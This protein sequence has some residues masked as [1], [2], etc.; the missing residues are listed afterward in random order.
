VPATVTVST[1]W[2]TAVEACLEAGGDVLLLADSWRSP[3]LCTLRPVL[4]TQL[5]A[6]QP[7]TL[8]CSAIPHPALAAFP[9]AFHADWQWWDLVHE[10]VCF[11]LPVE[12]A[13][14]R[15]IVQAIDHPIRNQK[16][17]V[18]FE[19]RVGSGRLLACSLD[20][21]TDLTHRSVARQLL[22]SLLT[23]MESPH[24]APPAAGSALAQAVL[25]PRVD[26]FLPRH[27]ISLKADQESVAVSRQDPRWRLEHFWATGNYYIR[28]SSYPHEILIELDAE[29]KIDGFLYRPRQDG[30]ARVAGLA[31]RSISAPM[32]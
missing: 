11:R 3:S 1:E 17:G 6:D 20:L 7:K 21:H 9:T 12:P 4:E 19:A 18:L 31:T 32:G 30:S 14:L 22:A 8:A 28:S 25:R 23:Y 27:A 15:P 2:N 5:F 29:F 13:A 10:A 24:F 16:F 26:H